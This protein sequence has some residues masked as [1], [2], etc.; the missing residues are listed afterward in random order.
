MQ[1]KKSKKIKKVV[2]KL[3]KAQKNAL[4]QIIILLNYILLG[5]RA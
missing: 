3:I 2:L 4:Q 5:V 1:V